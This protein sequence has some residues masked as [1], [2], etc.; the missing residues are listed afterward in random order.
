MKNFQKNLR[1]CLPI[2]EKILEGNQKP[3][4]KINKQLL[5]KAIQTAEK[6]M[7]SCEFC[8]RKC[9]INRLKDKRGFCKAGKDWRIFGAHTHMGEEI[10]LIPSG[11]LFLAGCA[12]RC[13]YCQNAPESITPELGQIW[14]DNKI[15]E[16]IDNKFS[17]GC[18]N[19][20]FVT[21]DCYVWNILK[22]LK[23]VK[24]DIPVVW[25]S[26]SYYS[27]KTA[28]LIKD[29]VDVY[30]LDF[31]Y[32]NNK[33]AERLSNAPGYVATAQR[34]HLIANKYG[35]LLIR[36]LVIP[37]HIECCAEPILKWIKDNLGED[38]RVN[39]MAQYYPTWQAEKFEDINRR[40]T[41]EEYEDVVDYAKRIGLKNLV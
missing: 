19:V 6:I 13:C 9:K 10:D 2:Y 28:N 40:L 16:W 41:A 22:A 1:K 36:V 30:L 27:E 12:L 5:D 18:K 29:F 15:A 21:P 23:L 4:F 8:E 32:F 35:E 20:N 25:N 17:E 37:N 11:T 14:Q 38:T 26:S 33:C 3:K 39:I 7:Q 31:R 24:S 34:N